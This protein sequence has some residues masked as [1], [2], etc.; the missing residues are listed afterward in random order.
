VDHLQMSGGLSAD[1]RQM[2]LQLNF[3][4]TE[5]NHFGSRISRS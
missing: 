4:A 1:E 5:I 2:I 3:G